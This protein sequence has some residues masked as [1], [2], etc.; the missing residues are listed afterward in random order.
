MQAFC[1]AADNTN[2]F[3]DGSISETY[4]TYKPSL[5]FLYE[6][7]IRVDVRWFDAGWYVR[8]DNTPTPI[9]DIPEWR[10]NFL[11]W[12]GTVG[13]WKMDEGKWPIEDGVS[14]FKKYLSMR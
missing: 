6:K 5:D 8:P 2:P 3:S 12:W 10:S 13:T 9:D 11:D 4:K 7:G 1:L 14:S